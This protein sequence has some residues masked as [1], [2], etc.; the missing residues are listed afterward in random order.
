MKK[1]FSILGLILTFLLIY[2]LQAN[3]FTWF[4]I[5]GIKPNLFIVFILFIG[6]FIGNKLGFVFGLILGIYL[7]LLIGKSIGIS[8]IMLA[9]V[10]LIGEY[11]DNNFSKDSRVTLILMVMGST[12]VYELGAYIFQ[13]LRWNMAIEILPFI[14]TV[15][16][17][18][19]FNSVLVIILYPLMQK[20]GNALER[21]FKNKSVL[22]RYF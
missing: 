1:F 11:L 3:F 12:A 2:F 5:A 8:G 18:V 9:I 4:N 14:K 20:A 10:G 6:L 21:L 7:D 22:T 13:I 17:E 16:I 15:L 19:I